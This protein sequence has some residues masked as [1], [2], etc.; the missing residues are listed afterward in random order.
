MADNFDGVPCPVPGLDRCNNG[1]TLASPTVSPDPG[2]ELT[3]FVSFAT[4][5]LTADGNENIIVR[6]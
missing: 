4:R 3:V 2:R 1:N 5:N 6:A